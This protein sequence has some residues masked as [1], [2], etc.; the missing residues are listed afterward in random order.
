MQLNMLIA[1]SLFYFMCTNTLLLQIFQ[2]MY[3]KAFFEHLKITSILSV[4]NHILV[5]IQLKTYF[6]SLSVNAK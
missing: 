5:K 3:T 4:K 6:C 2:I 1:Y